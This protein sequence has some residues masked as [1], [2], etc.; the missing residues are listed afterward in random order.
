[1]SQE[2]FFFFCY[3]AI[4]PTLNMNSDTSLVVLVSLDAYTATIYQPLCCGT[5]VYRDKML[6]VLGKM[7]TFT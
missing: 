1:M 5:L 3:L 2:P 6:G 7:I 4:I